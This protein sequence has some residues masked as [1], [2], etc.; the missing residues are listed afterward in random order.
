MPTERLRSHVNH[1]PG[2]HNFEQENREQLY[3]M[4]GD[5]FFSRRDGLRSREIPSQ[6]EIKTAAAIA[7][8]IARGQSR[9][10]SPRR[11]ACWPMCPRIRTYPRK[12]RLPKPGSASSAR[13]FDCDPQGAK[14]RRHG[15]GAG[16]PIVEAEAG[17]ELD[18]A[19]RRVCPASA[20]PRG[21]ARWCSMIAAARAAGPTV[22]RRLA[23]GDRVWAV[24]PRVVG[25][26][27]NQ[28]PGPG[29]FVSVV[30]GGGRRTSAGNSGGPVGRHR[31]LAA[32]ASSRFAAHD[33]C[34][35][36]AARRWR[37]SWRRP[38]SRRPFR[39]PK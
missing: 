16:R 17:C 24:D 27:E 5:F 34:R 11:W 35:R 21:M 14:I 29:L 25:R 36:S 7:R 6:A 23:A 31:P 9:F 10:S 1:V 8:A 19:G 2:T 15:G 18:R 30:R 28:G 39:R 20:A 38:S 22:S 3:A 13:A 26:I 32:Q 37:R 4:L 12:N 33:R